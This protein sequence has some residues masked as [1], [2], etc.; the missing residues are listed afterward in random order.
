[1]EQTGLEHRVGVEGERKDHRRKSSN[2][3]Q[4]VVPVKQS[5][6][7]AVLIQRART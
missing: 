1:M 5:M 2:K 7:L 6:V 4:L 3:E